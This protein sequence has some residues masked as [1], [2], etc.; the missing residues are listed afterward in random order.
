MTR[1]ARAVEWERLL[2]ERALAR[3]ELVRNLDA[4]EERARDPFRLK[5]RIRR[6]P[7]LAAGVAAAAGALAV[8]VLFGRREP[9]ADPRRP[10]PSSSA[11][12]DDGPDLL[13]ALGDAAV[14]V[15]T[16]WIARLLDEHL[17]PN[18]RG[19]GTADATTRSPPGASAAES[20]PSEFTA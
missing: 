5:Q 14:R 12:A 7:V 19:S 15:A 1:D 9:E 13:R 6:H 17:A 8:R 10:P 20:S 2:A 3:C 18:G 11:P 4:L 16:P